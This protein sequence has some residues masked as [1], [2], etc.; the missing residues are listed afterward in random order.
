MDVLYPG[1]DGV[2]IA[3]GVEGR[4]EAAGFFVPCEAPLPVGSEVVLRGE[5]N[6]KRGKVA[7]V[8][9]S[10]I[11]GMWL[12][13]DALPKL[14]QPKPAPTAVQQAVKAQDEAKEDDE[15]EGDDDKGGGKPERRKRS[16]K[17]TL[18]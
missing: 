9:E 18:T 6:D 13:G 17:R 4:A 8:A 11:V 2:V 16:R 15:P 1:K 12:S 3:N 7:R 5:G 10:G 14:E